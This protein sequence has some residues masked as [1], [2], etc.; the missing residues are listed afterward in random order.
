MEFVFY[1]DNDYKNA[2]EELKGR[3]EKVKTIEGTHRL[4]SFKPINTT[5]IEIKRYSDGLNSK[6]IKLIR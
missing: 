4:H 2:A 6:I 1:S 3:Y 5:E